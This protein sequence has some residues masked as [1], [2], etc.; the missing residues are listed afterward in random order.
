MKN[1]LSVRENVHVPDIIKLMD[2]EQKYKEAM[3]KFQRVINRFR[4]IDKKPRD[5]GTGDKLFP[6]EI[7]T[8]AAIGEHPSINVTDLSIEMGVTKSAIS[9]IVKKLEA[10]RYVRRYRE[11]DNNKEVLLDLLDDG[12]MAFWGHRSYHMAMDK[13]IIQMLESTTAE[14]MGFFDYFINELDK[15]A[16]D[17]IKERS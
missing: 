15:Y 14:Q 10:K 3:D 1:I 5:F 7:H 13:P 9:Q 4:E 11:E 2:D 12:K 8:I 16:Q 6:S 17:V